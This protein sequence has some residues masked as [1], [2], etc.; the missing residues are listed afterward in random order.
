VRNEAAHTR[1]HREPGEQA[2]RALAVC[3]AGS[4]ALRLRQQVGGV[5]LGDQM[6]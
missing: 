4:V 6:V 2:G 5:L 1:P 3:A